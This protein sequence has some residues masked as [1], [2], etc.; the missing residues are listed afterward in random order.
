M[1]TFAALGR[2]ER[3]DV[4]ARPDERHTLPNR[5]DDARALVAEDARR[6]PRRIGAG[7]RVQI[8]VADA[9]GGQ[10]DEHLTR[11][12]LGELDVLDDERPPELLEHRGTDP[13]RGDPTVAW[14]PARPTATRRRPT[15]CCPARARARARLPPEP[16]TA[17]S[18]C[19][20]AA[21]ADRTPGEEFAVVGLE[22]R[23]GPRT[24]GLGARPED[25]AAFATR[26]FGRTATRTAGLTSVPESAR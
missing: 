5:L 22:Q 12:G 4:V 19:R 1:D 15:P 16:G 11:L 8:G 26:T 23:D 25:A 14:E 17:P 13:H 20:R 21:P 18:T 24:R 10:P 3:D 9:A 7:G 2:E 6:I